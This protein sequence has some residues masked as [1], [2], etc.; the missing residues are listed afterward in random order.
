MSWDS[1]IDN[2]LAQSKDANGMVHGDMACIIGIEDGSKW[3]TDGHPN[4]LKI[5][6]EEAVTISNCFKKN[7]MTSFQASGVNISGVKYQFL[8]EIDDVVLAKKKEFGAITIQK[9]KTAIVIGHTKEGAQQGN[10]NKAVG[11]IADYLVSLNM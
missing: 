8:R 2:L 9:S 4:S 7:D 5:T 1:Y 6:T 11:V 10:V 3:T